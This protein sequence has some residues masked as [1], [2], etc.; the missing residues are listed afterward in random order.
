M[1]NEIDIQ[2]DPVN[3]GTA[4]LSRWPTEAE[5]GEALDE[6]VKAARSHPEATGTYTPKPGAAELAEDPEKSAGP[7]SEGQ[8]LDPLQCRLCDRPPY[9]RQGD[10]TKHTA[11]EHPNG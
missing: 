9:K 5:K 6:L 8:D 10:L 3:P 2:G 11:K 7:T 4:R 1:S